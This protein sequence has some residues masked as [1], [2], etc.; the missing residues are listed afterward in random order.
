MSLFV[1]SCREYSPML[2]LKNISG[3][4][5]S[6]GTF[7][8]LWRFAKQDNGIYTQIFTHGF[9]KNVQE[10]KSKDFEHYAEDFQV[11]FEQ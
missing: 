3:Y 4:L 9:K 6:T 2:F 8:N 1:G 5:Q 11:I 10:I 7:V